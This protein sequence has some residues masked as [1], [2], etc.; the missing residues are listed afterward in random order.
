MTANEVAPRRRT[1]PLCEAMCGLTLEVSGDRVL[2]VRGDPEDAF[3][4]G[5]ICPK[6]VG[7]MDVHHDPDRL[8]QPLRR[9]NGTWERV[10][11]DDAVAETVKR[12]ADIRRTHGDDAV[13][14]YVGNPATH[15]Y[16]AT[17]AAL[18]FARA[19]NTRNVFSTASVDFLPHTF[20]AY[21]SFG[22]RALL[23]VPDVDRT[24]FLLVFGA[25]PVVSNGSLMSAPNITRRLKDLRSR[26]GR[27]VVVDPRRT[28]TAALAGTNPIPASSGQVTRYRLNRGGDRQLNRALHTILLVRLRIDPDTRTYMARRTAEGKS[29]RDAK[30]CLRR[31]IARQLFRLLERYDQPGVE[32]LRTG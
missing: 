5:Y 7:L 15:S 12:L 16:S 31:V 3:S 8:G 17:L 26:G 9:R 23:P 18:A 13:A 22:N 30:R 2:A 1:C 21:H 24:H 20:A 28:R 19:L 4:R 6:A 32:I 14:F 10:E 27:L 29:R 25:N 11:W